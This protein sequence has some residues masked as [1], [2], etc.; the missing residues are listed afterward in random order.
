MNFLE[1]AQ[2]LR[3]KCRVSGS[4]PTA[5]TGQNEEYSRLIDWVNEA[6]MS[7]QMAREDWQWMR[8]DVT[9]TTVN[10]QV[11]YSASTDAGLTDFGNWAKD[12]FRNYVTASGTSSEI[13]MDWIEYD[14]WRNGY[15][16]GA[17]RS[18]YTRPLQ[19]TIG[20]DKS[21]S[22]GPIAADGYTIVG[23]Y[24]KVPTEL[25]ASTDEPAL[26]SR[27]HMAII[28]RAMMYY[29]VSEAAPEVYAEGER[30]FGRMM[31]QININQLPS[32]D[33]QGALA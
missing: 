12:A 4:G 7:I 13:P 10:G 2:R 17:L 15:Y 16:L 3:R 22:F 5:V 23:Q 18:V 1:L 29:G 28:Y 20:P 25:S 19:F 26:P 9:F 31:R 27:F 33:W 24:Y 21:L 11:S 32:I 6:W 30:E 8:R 14:T